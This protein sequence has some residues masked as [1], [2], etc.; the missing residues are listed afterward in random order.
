MLT[1]APDGLSGSS[2]TKTCKEAW[3]CLRLSKSCQIKMQIRENI[4]CPV[5]CA[6]RNKLHEDGRRMKNE[7][8]RPS[9]GERGSSNPAGSKTT[10]L[11]SVDH[12]RVHSLSITAFSNLVIGFI[13]RFWRS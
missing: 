2:L 13:T 5:R 3:G 6:D 12:H 9:S 10:R 11:L 7:E 8:E 1:S 4:C